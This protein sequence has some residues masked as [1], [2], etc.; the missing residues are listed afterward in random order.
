LVYAT[1]LGEH[2]ATWD[3]GNNDPQ[4]LICPCYWNKDDEWQ[5]PDW[6][7]MGLGFDLSN[8]VVYLCQIEH[9]PD[10]HYLNHES[11]TEHGSIVSVTMNYLY[12]GAESSW[13]VTCLLEGENDAPI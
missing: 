9:D 5:S 8:G 1:P 6:S 2:D 10:G 12:D 7:E 13:K 3:E 4:E 11:G